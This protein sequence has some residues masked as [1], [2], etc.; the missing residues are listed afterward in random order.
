MI[1]IK[2]GE[3][4]HFDLHPAT[5]R[6]YTISATFD[7]DLGRGFPRITARSSNGSTISLPVHFSHN[8]E[9]GAARMELPSGTYT[10]SANVRSPDGIEEG[11]TVVTVTNHDLSGVVFHLAPVPTLPVEFQLDS[12]ATSENQ[13]PSILQF[14]LMLED[15]RL[16]AD[17]FVSPVSLSASRGGNMAFTAPPGSYRLRARNDA[18]GW[19]IKSATYGASDLLQQEM[20]VAPGSGGTPI[21]ITVSDQTAS[22]QGTCKLGGLPTDCWVYLIPTTPSA[23]SVFTAHGNAQGVYNYARL[24]PGSYQAISFE[25]MHSADYGDPAVLVPFAT[26]VRTITINAGEKPT[27]DLDAVPEAEMYR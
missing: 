13:Q 4:Q 14:G 16:D 9:S 5:S 23:A 27:L 8:G 3:E 11:E 26:Y 19:Y 15:D 2:S 18:G 6:A 24:P 10:L 1:H 20:V 17:T 25:Q 21:R 22:L 7:S 12:T